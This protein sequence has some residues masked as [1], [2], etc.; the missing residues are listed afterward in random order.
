MNR[1]FIAPSRLPSYAIEG[2]CRKHGTP[3]PKDMPI[4]PACVYPEGTLI[5]RARKPRG[6]LSGVPM[7]IY[8]LYPGGGV[9]WTVVSQDQFEAV[10]RVLTGEVVP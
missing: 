4:G 6:A 8:A 1:V 10:M 9:S 3:L 7:C 2:L 5:V